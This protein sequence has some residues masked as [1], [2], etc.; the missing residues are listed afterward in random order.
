MYGRLPEMLVPATGLL[1]GAEDL[2][3]DEESGGDSRKA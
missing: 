2:R 3:A 1:L